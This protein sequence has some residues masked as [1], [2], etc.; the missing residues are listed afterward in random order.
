MVKNGGSGEAKALKMK[1]GRAAE[2]EG[3]LEEP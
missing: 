3:K 1:R 2:E